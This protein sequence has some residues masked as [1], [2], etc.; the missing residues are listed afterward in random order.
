MAVSCLLMAVEEAP[1]FFFKWLVLDN[2]TILVA[3]D[4]STTT[5]ISFN[6][7]FHEGFTTILYSLLRFRKHTRSMLRLDGRCFELLSRLVVSILPLVIGLRVGDCLDIWTPLKDH[8]KGFFQKRH[9]FYS[10]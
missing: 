10:G 1:I 9:L 5:T 2:L 3:R 6:E 7:D 4:I 8:I